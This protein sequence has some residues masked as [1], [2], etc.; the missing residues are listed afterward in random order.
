MGLVARILMGC[1]SGFCAIFCQNSS[2][3][4]KKHLIMKRYGRRFIVSGGVLG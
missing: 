4:K 3:I 1:V 2:F